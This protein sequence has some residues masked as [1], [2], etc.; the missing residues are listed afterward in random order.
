MFKRIILEEWHH[1]LPMVGFLFFFGFFCCLSI[2]TLG[3][4]K[5][6]ERKYARLPFDSEADLKEDKTDGQ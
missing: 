6:D 3:M 1:A 5:Q 4:R 2:R